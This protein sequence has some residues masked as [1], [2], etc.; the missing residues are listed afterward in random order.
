MIA[1]GIGDVG[2]VAA[3]LLA[4]LAIG[5]L[6]IQQED[7]DWVKA[8]VDGN[9]LHVSTEEGATRV[10]VL[11]TNAQRDRDRRRSGADAPGGAP[12]VGRG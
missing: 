5:P 2:I 8:V 7:G 10:D 9:F 6:Q 11:A 12:C 1:H 4:Q 3:P